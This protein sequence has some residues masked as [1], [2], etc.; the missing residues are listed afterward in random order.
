MNFPEEGI[1]KEMH[2]RLEAH[3]S[4]HES[5]VGMEVMGAGVHWHIMVRTSN[6]MAVIHCFDTEYLFQL[7]GE[8]EVEATARTKD[9]DLV[10]NCVGDWIASHSLNSL[11]DR[12]DFV[13]RTKRAFALL[14]KQLMDAAPELGEV[15]FKNQIHDGEYFNFDLEHGDRSCACESW[16][17]ASGP[18]FSFAWEG[19]KLF[20]AE[21]D[22][23]AEMA[24]AIKLWLVDQV[25]PSHFE[26]HFPWIDIGEL[27]RYYERGEGLKGEFLAS[28]D[29]MEEFYGKW[30][31]EYMDVDPVR[32]LMA[33]LR[34]KGYDEQLRAGQSLS[35]LI[36]SRSR[37]HGMRPEQKFVAISFPD[38][39]MVVQDLA[40][41]EVA[42][43]EV[44]VVP[45]L[46]RLL[47]ELVEEEID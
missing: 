47:D 5:G 26:T 25:P 16:R 45:E 13:D 3:F 22:S 18:K 7:L 9:P 41:N 36:L 42:Y 19:C 33:T 6:R 43:G 46:L 38:E 28:W 8:N 30:M 32:E 17:K 12:Y 23:I 27:A 35:T 14:K 21:H 10:V 34:E 15:A 1:A 11:Y 20:E 4:R 31:R 44:E 39:G 37:R 40:G 2:A 24:L 29:K